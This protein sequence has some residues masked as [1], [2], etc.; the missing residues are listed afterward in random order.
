MESCIAIR[1]E[2][3]HTRPF[4]KQWAQAA[5]QS[6]SCGVTYSYKAN[7][8]THLG[9]GLTCGFSELECTIRGRVLPP[10]G[11]PTTVTISLRDHERPLSFDGTIT[12]VAGDCF[13]V[14]LAELQARDHQRILHW[15]W[16]LGYVNMIAW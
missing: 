13:G 16:D 14:S 3:L 7:G 10:V 12:S 9:D 4:L 8:R 6:V 5:L 11:S 1:A 2:K 15:L